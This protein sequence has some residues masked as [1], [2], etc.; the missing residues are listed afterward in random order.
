MCVVKSFAIPHTVFGTSLHVVGGSRALVLFTLVVVILRIVGQKLMKKLFLY[1][2]LCLSVHKRY[3]IP[4]GQS[5]ETGSIE[6]TSW[7]QTKQQQNTMCVRLTRD[8]LK[9][10]NLVNIVSIWI[11]MELTCIIVCIHKIFIVV[12][13]SS[14]SLKKNN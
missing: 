11:W 9:M 10:V 2:T 1:L 8:I 12:V 3:K 13:T 7:R 4:N 14:A 5:R 6:N